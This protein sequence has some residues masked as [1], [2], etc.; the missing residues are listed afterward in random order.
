MLT[1][2]HMYVYYVLFY[3]CIFKDILVSAPRR[4]QDNSAE[5]CR[6]YVKDCSHK[7]L[8]IAF[9]RVK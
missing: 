2:Q 9:V 6:S 4:C 7:L 8:N 1:L 5:T 3:C